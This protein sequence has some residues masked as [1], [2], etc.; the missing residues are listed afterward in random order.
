[1]SDKRRF[2]RKR[3]RLTVEF[4]WNKAPCTGFTYD[5]S[6]VGMFVRSIRLPTLGV[7]I[8]ARLILPGEKLVELRGIVVR[9]FRVPSSLVRVVPSGFGLRLEDRPE[10]YLQFLA[11]L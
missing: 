7:R 4:E 10:E 9:T 2:Q 8:K 11:S 1:M 6:P 5:I 3:R